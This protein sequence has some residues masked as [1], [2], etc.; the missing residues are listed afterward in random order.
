MWHPDRNAHTVE[1]AR[2]KF[3]EIKIALDI[4]SDE[5]LRNQYDLKQFKSVHG[6]RRALLLARPARWCACNTRGSCCSSI[7]VARFALHRA[8]LTARSRCLGVPVRVCM[9][10]RLRPSTHPPRLPLCRHPQKPAAVNAR[11]ILRSLA[12]SASLAVL[13][14]PPRGRFSAV[15]R[16]S[17]QTGGWGRRWWGGETRAHRTGKGT[18][19]L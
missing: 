3:E 2:R 16:I 17:A 6:C 9:F 12:V 13:A 14:L 8:A 4:L 15:D 19:I 18:G 10:T 5:T 11:R 7:R 1:L